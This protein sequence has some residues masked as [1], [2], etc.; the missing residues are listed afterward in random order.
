MSY[1]D[2]VSNR[3]DIIAVKIMV[4]MRTKP[5]TLNELYFA[6]NILLFTKKRIA[7]RKN[8]FKNIH[9]RILSANKLSFYSDVLTPFLT[10]K[11]TLK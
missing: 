1:G 8:N 2:D 5:I 11:S 6:D 10:E 4:H 7:K 3:F 9:H